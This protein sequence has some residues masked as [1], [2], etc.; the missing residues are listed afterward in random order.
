MRSDKLNINDF[1]VPYTALGGIYLEAYSNRKITIQGRYSIN[2]YRDDMLRLR[3]GKNNLIIWGEGLRL[4]NVRCD[5]LTVMGYIRQ[6][7]YDE[8]REENLD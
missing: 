4:H 8:R 2:D 3:F 7:E 1:E 6:I 5:E